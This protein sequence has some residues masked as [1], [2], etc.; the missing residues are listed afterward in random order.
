MKTRLYDL[1]WQLGQYSSPIW[2]TSAKILDSKG[3]QSWSMLWPFLS[4]INNCLNLCHHL[5]PHK[6]KKRGKVG[7]KWWK[8]K[9]FLLL[10]TKLPKCFQSTKQNAT[11]LNS[12][13]SPLCTLYS[14]GQT[15]GILNV[16]LW[17]ILVNS[18]GWALT[19][20]HSISTLSKVSFSNL[21]TNDFFRPSYGFWE[22]F[23]FTPF[24][25]TLLGLVY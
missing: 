8:D 20:T 4:K 2:M 18:Y 10:S 7:E 23:I 22:F 24:I 5:A 16:I 1:G 21:L 6:N 11:S 13:Q 12:L 25:F 17:I 19:T 15:G 14:K 3:Q 9:L